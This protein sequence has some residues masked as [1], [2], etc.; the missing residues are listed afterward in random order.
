MGV[1]VPKGSKFADSQESRI[2]VAKRSN[3]GSAEMKGFRFAD[4]LEKR[5]QAWK[6][7]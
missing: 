6:R 5:F 3:M 2:Q 7:S 1:T 4:A